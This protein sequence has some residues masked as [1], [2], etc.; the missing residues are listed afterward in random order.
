MPFV[1]EQ[2][3]IDR[4][5]QY[6]N[7]PVEGDIDVLW[8][9]EALHTDGRITVQAKKPNDLEPIQYIVLGIGTSWFTTLP[10]GSL[11]IPQALN[12]QSNIVQRV[13][14]INTNT[15]CR[16]TPGFYQGM[17]NVPYSILKPNDSWPSE[18][19]QGF[20]TH[21]GSALTRASQDYVYGDPEARFVKPIMLATDTENFTGQIGSSEAGGP[22]VTETNVVIPAGTFFFINQVLGLLADFGEPWSDVKPGESARMR[23]AVYEA[24]KSYLYDYLLQWSTSWSLQGGTCNWSSINE[25]NYNDPAV[26]GLTIDNRT[27]STILFKESLPA[28]DFIGNTLYTPFGFEGLIISQAAKSVT[29]TITQ[30]LDDEFL[31]GYEANI[32][33]VTKIL[34]PGEWQDF[35]FPGEN[36]GPISLYAGSGNFKDSRQVKDD[37]DAQYT[38]PQGA[39]WENFSTNTAA[40][41]NLLYETWRASSHFQQATGSTATGVAALEDTDGDTATGGV[42]GIIDDLGLDVDI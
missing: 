4:M 29:V 14:E 10:I 21:V 24:V 26:E 17:T 37:I 41:V 34:L 5:L 32:V 22:L 9:N 15:S 33:P 40:A 12:T 3:I 18:Q 16:V 31:I 27:E 36:Y 1:E 30:D 7:R 39:G 11:L 28:G 13:V 23:A 35:H 25:I 20:A 8:P 6:Y 38:G 19:I 42:L 2:Q